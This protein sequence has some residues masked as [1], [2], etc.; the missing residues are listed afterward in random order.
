MNLAPYLA[1][2]TALLL[3][4]CSSSDDSPD[5]LTPDGTSELAPDGDDQPVLSSTPGGDTSA[6][7]GYWDGSQNDNEERYFII[8]DNGLWTE[9]FLSLEGNTPGNCYWMADTQ[10]LTPEDPAANE[11]SL[12]DGR[13]LAMST[14]DART[15]L[16]VEYV[17]EERATEVWPAIVGRVPEDLPLCTE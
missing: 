14:D 12:A 3:G 15:A 1:I 16:T 10:T 4:A 17:I 5:T 13:A 6:I 8:A 11:Y 9:Y 2:A 7:A